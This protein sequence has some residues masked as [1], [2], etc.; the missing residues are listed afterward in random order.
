MQDTKPW[1]QSRAIW[2]A[3]VAVLAGAASVWGYSVS[4][5]DQQ[6][7]VELVTGVAAALGGIGALVGRVMATH[8]LTAGAK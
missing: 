4:A 8:Q 6:Q 3:L 2:S 7:V 5:A 1:W